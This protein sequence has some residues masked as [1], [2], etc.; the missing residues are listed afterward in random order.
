MGIR[1]PKG[2]GLHVGLLLAGAVLVAPVAVAQDAPP[3]LTLSVSLTPE[4]LASFQP[5]LAALDAASDQFDVVLQQTP[6]SGA[7]EKLNAQLA[8]NDLPDVIRIQGLMAQNPIRRG[9]FLD[10]GPLAASLDPDDFFAGPMEQ[11]GWDGTSWGIPDTA[12]PDVLFYNTAL[13]DA[14]GVPYPTDN[15]TTDDLRAAALKLTLDSAGRS[16]DD[17]AFDPTSIVQWGWNAGLTMIW[18]RHLLQSRGWDVCVRDDCTEMDWDSPAAVHAA[19][20]WI[21]LARDLHV[22]PYDPYRGSQTGVP[23][24]PFLVGIAAMGYNGYFAVGQLAATGTIAYDI[25]QPVLG[26]DGERYTPLSTNGYVIAADTQHPEAAQALVAALVDPAFLAQTWGVPGHS[27]PARISAA[28]SVID[29]SRPPAH[30]SAIVDAMAY[31]AVFQPSTGAAFEAYSATADLF[32]KANTGELTTE[33][34]MTQVE[35]AAN[36]ALARDRVP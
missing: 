11:F 31:G 8:A 15:W 26:I 1:G 33:Q 32:T 9:A 3:T 21:S 16:A 5:A 13:F 34:A 2:G 30:Q 10:L 14:A 19:D 6:Q 28:S 22:T 4:E 18:Q 23:G 17:P 20:W 7:V 25:A 29:P 27:V 24:D 12:A 35:A 36:E